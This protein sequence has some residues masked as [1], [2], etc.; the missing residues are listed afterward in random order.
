MNLQAV[1]NIADAE[2]EKYS[3]SGLLWYLL[4]TPSQLGF[5]A[6]IGVLVGIV[7][8]FIYEDNKINSMKNASLIILWY[9]VGYVFYTMIDLKEARFNVHMLLPLFFL[10]GLAYDHLEKLRNHVGKVF[11]GLI[12]ASSLYA[13]L[14]R[15]V[16]YVSGYNHVA[17][18]IAELAPEDSNVL[19]SGYRDGS[20]IF[21][22]RAV[23]N[24][25]DMST[26][27]ADKLLLQIASRREI[28]VEEKDYT[29]DQ[30][31]VMINELAINYVVA[32]PD[33]WT[34]LKQM[35]LLQELLES[36]QFEEVERYQLPRNYNSQEKELI[37][38]KNLGQVAQGPVR[39]EN[40]LSIIGRTVT[41][42]EPN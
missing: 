23:A 4:Q 29:I 28:G 9:L 27:R 36:D 25:D 41:S 17:L 2:V 5:G 21:A 33:F 8:F 6:F 18:E 12:V 20:F 10:I 31:A 26:V 22:M 42:D 40:E 19:F 37:I 15:P 30:I 34:D 38:Y 24:R 7:T 32:Q 3:L 1:T 16:E 39:I 14:N 35:A 13:T 11:I